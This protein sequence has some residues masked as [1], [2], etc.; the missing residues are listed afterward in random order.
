MGLTLEIASTHLA[1]GAVA[2]P[3]KSH[4]LKVS[5]G[6]ATAP[7]NLENISGFGSKETTPP[8][9]GSTHL[10]MMQRSFSSRL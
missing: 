1:V 9:L 10:R 4:V 8:M 2:D 5:V 3:T 7:A 6:R